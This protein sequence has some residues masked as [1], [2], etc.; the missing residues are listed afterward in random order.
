[1]VKKGAWKVWPPDM[2]VTADRDRLGYGDT[3]PSVS[4]YCCV[5][6][7]SGGGQRK[8]LSSFSVELYGWNKG[9]HV[10]QHVATVS[11]SEP[12]LIKLE[13]AVEYPL[14]HTYRES[15]NCPR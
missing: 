12:M 3:Q 5:Y 11:V 6:E 2:T 15:S 14:G 13:H 10:G 7:V 8:P 9:A 1:V 4:C